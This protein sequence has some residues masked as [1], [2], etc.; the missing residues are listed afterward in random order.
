MPLV[1]GV[2]FKPATKVYY[3]DPAGLSDLREGDYVLVETSRARELGKVVIPPKEVPPE[4]VVGRLKPILGRATSV[5]LASAQHYVTREQQALEKCRSKVVEHELPIKVIRAEY[6]YDGSHLTLYFTAEKRVDFRA[7]VKDLARLFRTRIELRQV[8]VRDEAK[9]ITG[10]GPCG[11]PLCCATHL[12]E[13]IPVSIKMAK[14]QD[15]PLSPMEISGM[16]GRLMCC[17]TYEDEFYR[18]AQAKMPRRGETITTAD[19]V[20]RVRGYNVIKETVQVELESGTVVEVPLS[21]IE[22]APSGRGPRRRR[23]KR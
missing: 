8:G 23:S 17:L 4:E 22:E 1:V 14:Q 2:R 13:F 5:D 7:L 9:L 3:F 15:L 19:G 10:F 6:N 18:E 21:D 20:G 16:C 12:C 11:R